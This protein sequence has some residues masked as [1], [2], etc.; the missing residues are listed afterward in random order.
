MVSI[1]KAMYFLVQSCVKRDTNISDFF[2]CPQG[3]KQGCLLSP[4][5]FSLHISEVVDSVRKGGKH[6]I[7]LLPGHDEFF[8]LLFADDIVLVSST[9]SGLQ[10]QMNNLEKA[11][12]SLCLTV[13]LDKIKAKIFRKGGHISVGE[14]WLYNGAEIEVVNSYR[15]H[16]N[17]KIVNYLCL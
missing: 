16:S 17:N 15:L 8:S 3:V 10:N 11:S 1:L 14:K 5:F 9:P 2:S 13:N 12:K 7:Q 6:N 4:L